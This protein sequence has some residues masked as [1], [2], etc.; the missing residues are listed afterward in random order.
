MPAEEVSTNTLQKLVQ[1]IGIH[2]SETYGI[3]FRYSGSGFQCSFKGKEITIHYESSSSENYIIIELNDKL[4]HFHLEEG[5]SKLILKD[6]LESSELKV[7]KQTEA[8]NG[9]FTL[10][11]L[12]G[13]SIE[14][15]PLPEKRIIWIGNSI[16]CG[17]GNGVAIPAPPKG[18]P[19][20]GYHPENQINY[21]AYSSIVSRGFQAEATQICFS[22]KGIYR[23][24]DQSTTVLIPEFYSQ[25]VPGDNNTPIPAEQL[26]AD[27]Y[28]IH[29]GT[30]DFGGEIG[31]EN[32]VDSTLF[33]ESYLNLLTKI[34]MNHS[35]KKVLLLGSNMLAE[36][37]ALMQK[38]RL[39][40]YLN[41][42][43][44]S[45]QG[46]LK[47]YLLPLEY[48]KAPYGEN[49]HPSE[50]EHIRMADQVE[51]FIRKHALL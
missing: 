4:H 30:N 24:Y 44:K 50:S 41:Q 40:Q 1:P 8:R 7:F 34:E 45:Y 37:G 25:Q 32:L 29:S 31:P 46:S 27:L 21:N 51:N 36:G 47:L 22:G 2:Q 39:L 16:T 26:S 6:S 49:W 13:D 10:I 14:P 12:E 38:E 20:T 9:T 19:A 28:V 23:N 11:D 17:Y 42:V 3:H 35:G 5:K 18:N 15:I 43:I 48:M 33:V